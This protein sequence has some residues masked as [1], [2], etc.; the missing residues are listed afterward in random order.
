L[1]MDKEDLR[2]ECSFGKDFIT[3]IFYLSDKNAGVI[4]ISGSDEQFMVWLDV[5]GRAHV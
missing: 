3:Y 1:S 2:K 4:R 5:I